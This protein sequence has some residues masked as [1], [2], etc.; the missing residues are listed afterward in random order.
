MNKTVK[1]LL[2]AQAVGLVAATSASAATVDLTGG[3][4][5]S[6]GGAAT[7]QMTK[8]WAL[9]E[10]EP[11]LSMSV[12]DGTATSPA[13]FGAVVPT[14][15]SG[16]AC[17]AACASTLFYEVA[18]VEDDIDEPDETFTVGYGWSG[19]AAGGGGAG[20][21]LYTIVDD[22]PTPS[23][24]INDKTVGE[25]DGA[26]HFTI[27]L[28]NPSSAAIDVPWSTAPGSASGGGVDFVNA[29]ATAH[30]APG[31]TTK[32][33]AV[34]I[35]DDNVTEPQ[36][37][38]L[39]N[40]AAP[41][42]GATLLDGQG[43]GKINDN[44]PPPGIEVDGGKVTEGNAGAADAKFEIELSHPSAFPIDVSFRTEDGTARA[45]DDYQ[46]KS[47]TVH[48]EP[49]Q[50]DK[51]VHVL[52]N[53]DTTDEPEETFALRLSGAVNARLGDEAKGKGTIKN[54]DVPPTVSIGSE[55]LREGE[56]G[57]SQATFTVTL[58]AASGYTVTVDYATAD[59]SAR[60]GSDYAA[61]HGTLT[62]APGQTR[63]QVTVTVNGDTA[64][65]P[66]ET[67]AVRLSAPVHVTL[68]DP[69][70]QGKIVNDDRDPASDNARG[71]DGDQQSRKGEQSGGGQGGARAKKRQRGPRV[72]VSVADALVGRALRLV[73]AC[74]AAEELC[75]GSVTLTARV[76]HRHH[77]ATG[78]RRL[79]TTR[80]RIA[81][82]DSR[83]V[84]VTLSKAARRF[85]A[86][87]GAATATVVARDEDG[88]VGVAKRRFHL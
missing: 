48:F 80:F 38:Y 14:A 69:E 76:A 28:S 84:S 62:F 40:L 59:G 45:G 33:I 46:S 85:L 36:E 44:D 41:A 61:E 53:G 31:E 6:E 34:P 24:S 74:P 67:F 87:G 51:D 30:F 70:G 8:V 17:G 11:T 2:L 3:G 49:G 60:A 47:G 68:G 23:V 81:G 57:A 66:D 27:S 43:E 54:D 58:S 75:R 26:A 79:G 18:T 9:T 7:V 4:N 12:T 56:S 22:D 82:G 37:S 64:V 50:T 63:K 42:A 13:D 55:S 10:P 35:V 29:S 39:V 71:G 77:R 16:S 19:G 65:E 32:D 83:K 78:A 21:A 73:I 88:N 20:A 86:G 72:R 1:T 25:A 52:V 15:S 5:V